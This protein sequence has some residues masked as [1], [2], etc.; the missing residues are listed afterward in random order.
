[1]VAS[2]FV[3]ELDQE[4]KSAPSSILA[5][6]NNDDRAI[7]L[8]QAEEAYATTQSLARPQP[9]RQS[10]NFAKLKH[11]LML[12]Y[13]AQQ[14]VTRLWVSVDTHENEGVVLR[15]SRG[16]YIASPRQIL[17]STFGKACTVLNL[18]AALTLRSRPIESL[19]AAS[20]GTNDIPLNEGLRMQVVSTMADLTTAKV[21]QGGC[22][23]MNAGLLVIWDDDPRNLIH[24]ASEIET[25]SR[26]MVWSMNGNDDDEFRKIV[27]NKESEIFDGESQSTTPQQRPTHLINTVLVA[28]CLI[29]IIVLIGLA[30]RSLAQ[31][32]AFDKSYI[33]L[34]FL[35]LIPLQIFF[36]LFFSQVIVSCIAQCCGPIRQLQINSK[37]YSA[38]CSPRLKNNLP[39]VTIQCPV[40]KEGLKAVIQPTIK[41][42]KQ[43]ISTYEL[44]GGSANI[45][46]NDDGLQLIDEHERKARIDFY[47]NNSIGWTARPKHGSE[48]FVRKGKF[49]K[50]SNMNY[51]LML[52]C[53][54]EEKLARYARPITW[55]KD[56]ESRAYETCFEATL[57]EV[58]RAWA[59]GNIRVGDYI[60]LIDS[61]TQ[62]PSDCLLDA[63]SEMEQ[64]PNVGIM[65]FSSGVMQ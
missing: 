65:Q 53:K 63:V 50:A 10:T 2:Q 64:S 30:C 13:I 46:V 11:D 54:I 16:E 45:F 15:T 28:L 35:L 6:N 5:L 58:P 32:I 42:I 52:S 20:A 31:E 22:F 48:G 18:S 55:T 26:Q 62:V 29:I 44:Q 27:Y 19:L 21:A 57:A 14:Q 17:D 49:K 36:S 9:D 12:S 47:A 41:S 61:D 59:A 51:G 1:M 4:H 23:I 34:L 8:Q 56:D 40:Y 37:F 3:E 33:R 38:V 25:Q 39:H 60:L 7:S 43:A 24:R